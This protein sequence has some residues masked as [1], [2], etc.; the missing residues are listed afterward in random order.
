MIINYN[1]NA[2]NKNE[3]ITIQIHFIIFILSKYL[4]KNIK[5]I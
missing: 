3:F 1:K 5:D 4:F 2:L